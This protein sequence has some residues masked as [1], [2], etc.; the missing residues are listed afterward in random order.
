MRS[1]EDCGES[2]DPARPVASL[3]KKAAPNAKARRTA[4]GAV[5]RNANAGQQK[6]PRRLP[7]DRGLGDTRGRPRA[8]GADA[9]TKSAAG[10]Q[11]V[12]RKP[13]KCARRRARPSCERAA[14][15]G[16]CPPVW[17]H[18][19]GKPKQA[20][21][22]RNASAFPHY[23]K[24]CQALACP[25]RAPRGTHRAAQWRYPRRSSSKS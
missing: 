16:I 7:Q 15:M 9:M 10:T 1:R 13:G 14:R 25:P 23:S 18:I 20:M 4:Y 12:M 21:G 5:C 17:I 19:W 8:P 6:T 2:N 11:Q 24:A 22:C 3:T